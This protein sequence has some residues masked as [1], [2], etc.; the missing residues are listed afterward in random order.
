MTQMLDMFKAFVADKDAADMYVTG[1]AG[2][3]KTTGLSACVEYCINEGISYAVTAYTHKACGVLRSKLPEGAIVTTLHAHIKKRPMVN[4]DALLIEHVQ[5]NIKTAKAE[6]VAVLFIDEY[7]IVG[8]KDL[9]D[10]RAEQ[11][12]EESGDIET[13]V[14]WLGDPNQLPPVGDA[15]AVR[16]YGKYK[17]TLTK[18]YRQSKD[19][20]L[21]GTLDKLVNFI[22]E[23]EKPEALQANPSFIRGVDI[24][25]EY[26]TKDDA[27]V[28]AFTNKRVEELNQLIEGKEQPVKGDKLFSPTTKHYYEFIEWLEPEEVFELDRPFGEPLQRGSKYKT[29][30]HLFSNKDYRYAKLFDV[31]LEEE[32]IVAF[33]FGHYAYKQYLDK[34]KAAAVDANSSIE[35]EFKVKATEWSRNNY[36]SPKAKNR[37]KAWRDFLSFNECVICLDFAHAM[38][39]HKSQGSTFK[40][41]LVDTDDIGICAER[42]FNLYL[43]LMYVALSRASAKVYTS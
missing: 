17:L 28:L 16:P 40:H 19:N 5:Q 33:I 41:V 23:K 1:R 2:T 43:R 29:L 6:K 42:N 35:K 11:E 21:T 32:C 14:V 26:K 25:E 3:G 18:V 39:V 9:M 37:A 7:S 10:I 4:S 38:T 31:E 8:E 15:E 13:K 24:A 34:L 20:P 30:E 12:N 22:E 36:D 27:V